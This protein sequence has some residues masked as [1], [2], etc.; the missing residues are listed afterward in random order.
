MDSCVFTLLCAGIVGL[1]TLNLLCRPALAV[2]LLLLVSRLMTGSAV[3]VGTLPIQRRR[4]AARMLA[5]PN[6]HFDW[7]IVWCLL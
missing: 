5:F 2:L 7:L 6:L 4:E 3:A 1:Q